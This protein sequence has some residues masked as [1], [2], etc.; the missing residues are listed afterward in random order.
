MAK[1]KQTVTPLCSPRLVGFTA[2][3]LVSC[4]TEPEEQQPSIEITDVAITTSE[5]VPSVVHVSWRTSA[6]STCTVD[7]GV[8][9][10]LALSR[11]EQGEPSTTH[12]LT[13]V[14]LAPGA[15][16]GMII[17]AEADGERSS[18]SELI[19]T[20]GFLPAAS[21]YVT[22]A[23]HDSERANGG[24][25]LVP[26]RHD[27]QAWISIIDDD[28]TV[29]WTC[30]RPHNSH[31]VLLAPDGSGVIFNEV[32]HLAEVDWVGDSIHHVDWDCQEVW[33]I[34]VP[35][36][37]HDFTML[38]QDRFAIIGYS[39][40]E[41]EIEGETITLLGDT[42]IEV[43]RDGTTRLLWDLFEENDVEVA[44]SNE[45]SVDQTIQMMDW[46]HGNYLSWQQEEQ[47][48]LVVLRHLDAVAAVDGESGAQR[49]MVSN[50][51]GDYQSASEPIFT[52]P[53]SSEL[54]G[55]DLLVFNQ[56][57]K[58]IEDTCSHSL[59]LSLDA[60]AGLATPADQYE[61]QECSK[62]SYLG[63]AQALANGNTLVT[64][65]DAGLVDEVTP[66]G[67]L[68]HRLQLDLGW[69]FSYG[70]RHDTLWPRAD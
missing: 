46:S 7:Y 16:G 59:L 54:V 51:W 48:Y 63:N 5:T 66:E 13:L 15:D 61:N 60:G 20:T 17:H 2:L 45:R 43:H 9:G 32:T 69:A 53:H 33:S 6:P 49:W 28:G 42:I 47:A 64:F 62:V 34:T 29:V 37:H 4:G 41:T 21:P 30:E 22:L 55:G 31:K 39:T 35:N 58:E 57:Y 26:I 23:Q 67:E 27:E 56:T 12:A 24:F 18:S 10:E 19:F 38:D 36:S 1:A 11:D 44:V 8:P 14:G 40:K 3:F 65:S 52:W 50:N 68:V 70:F 25:T